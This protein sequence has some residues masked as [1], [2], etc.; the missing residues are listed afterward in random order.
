S[1]SRCIRLELASSSLY[2]ARATGIFLKTLL[3][4]ISKVN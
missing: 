2:T 3:Y 4:N 1:E